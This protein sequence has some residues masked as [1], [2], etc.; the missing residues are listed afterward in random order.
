M[1]SRR[2]FITLLGGAAAAWP[3]DA[4]AQQRPTI[5]FI[6]G[7]SSAPWGQ[8]VAAFR[9]GL[10]ETGYVEGYNVTIE[11]RWAEGQYDRL[12]A[13]A[14]EMVR[15]QVAVIVSTGGA[16]AVLAAKAA[17]T[18]IPIVFSTGGD[19]VKLGLVA[20]LNRPGGNVT[21][22][23]VLTSLMDAKRLGLLREMVPNATLIAVL[24]NPRNPYTAAQAED[25]Q[26]GARSVGQNI[27][28]LNASTD[29]E[30]ET[31]FALL[32]SRG[33][34]A[35]LV[36]ADPFFNARREFL[37]ALAAR[38]GV[39]TIYEFREFAVAGGLMSYGTNLPEGYHQVGI[40]TGRILKGEKPADLPV[41]Q[42][43]KFQFVINFNAAKALGLDVP[44]SLSA[45]ADEV[46]E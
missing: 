32:K 7:A 44:P 23:A 18:T 19:P 20:S 37:I 12:P 27:T 2:E 5:G 35:L 25:T 22:V 36:G 41:Y 21:G 8:F 34:Q 24:V 17:T 14:A 4:R 3:F 13:M 45:R 42:V 26:V 6:S 30:I 31:A 9:Q 28:I 1:S 43:T 15:R 16:A 46:I 10:K 29:S 39:P 40:Y 33:A 38:H 11:F